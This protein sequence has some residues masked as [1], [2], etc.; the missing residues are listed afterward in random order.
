MDAQAEQSFSM[1]LDKY[2][3]SSY[4]QEASVGLAKALNKQKKFQNAHLILDFINKRWPRYYIDEPSFLLLQAGNDEALGKTRPALGLYWLY[5]NLVPGHEG[6][7]A[8][9][10]RLGD[11]YARQGG[12]IS[13]EFVYRY[14]ERMF[15]G[16]ASG[17]VARLRLAEKGIYDS[18]INYTEMSA[19]F[20]G[21]IR[22]FL[23]LEPPRTHSLQQPPIG[24]VAKFGEIADRILRLGNRRALA[25]ADTPG[26]GLVDTVS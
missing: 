4:L 23:K 15:A 20:V 11:M 26:D 1:V 7:D 10:L 14:V 21:G 9:L 3:E 2:P 8:L 16:T 5:Y 13:A 24:F 18:P 22:I 6:N 12:W 25:G 19:V 17:S